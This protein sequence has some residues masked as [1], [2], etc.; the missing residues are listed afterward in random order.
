MLKKSYHE[1]KNIPIEAYNTNVESADI[2]EYTE[3]MMLKYGINVN[4]ARAVTSIND[5]LIIGVRRILWTM[6][7][8]GLTPGKMTKA[9]EFLGRVQKYHP[10]GDLP[11]TGTFEQMSKYWETNGLLLDIQ[12]NQGSVSGANAA[13]ARYLEGCLSKYAYE[14][15][16]KEFDPEITDMMDNYTRTAKEP[17]SLPSKYPNFLMS[18]SEGIGWGISQTMPPFNFKEVC[19]T[20]IALI[21]DPTLENVYL[22]PDSPRGYEIMETPNIIDI[23]NEGTGSLAIRACIKYNKDGHYLSITGFPEATT[24]KDIISEISRLTS[25]KKLNGIKDVSDQTHFNHVEF[26]IHLKKEA[27]PNYI[28]REL[29][30]K[31]SCKGYATLNMNFAERTKI[32]HLGIKDALLLWIDRRIDQKQ[33][34][35]NKKLKELNERIHTLTILIWI[36]QSNKIDETIDIIRNSPT[37]EDAVCKL[38]NA[39]NISSYQADVIA[40]MKLGQFNKKHVGDWV[41]EYDKIQ[42]IIPKISEIV[43]SKAKIKEVIIDE[44]EDGI[45]MFGK[46]RACKIISNS[47]N[48]D[49]KY[50]IIVTKRYIKKLSS[51]THQ[52]GYLDSKDEVIGIF[53][54]MIDDNVIMLV[55]KKGRCYSF[56]ISKLVPND[57][58]SR[59]TELISSFG[60]KSDIVKAVNMNKADDSMNLIMFT[61]KGNIKKTPL[62]QYISKTSKSDF[63]GIILSDDDELCNVDMCKN[64]NEHWV[65]VYT[66]NGVGI[67]INMASITTTNKATMGGNFLKL[68]NGDYVVGSCDMETSDILIITT[69]GKMKIC[70]VCEVMKTT[71]RRQEMIRLTSLDNGDSVFRIIPVHDNMTHFTVIMQSGEKCLINI[72]DINRTTRISKGFK[73]INVKRNDS[74]IK[75]K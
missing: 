11:T 23:C 36:A 72:N 32:V 75:I 33:K 58:S 31:T 41:A 38:V 53:T 22:Y 35:Y 14:C 29:Y 46:P 62:S 43:R 54:S 19:E 21:K 69:K 71:K 61:K 51:Y 6:Y 57:L 60:V 42:S 4:L 10:H 55:D 8:L 45:R 9:S 1:M 30:S 52:I 27:D 39:Y 40:S 16:F 49:I 48:Y 2:S 59:G 7:E 63:T 37:M 68:D 26:W 74:I 66:N 5:G 44:L 15:F 34:I 17:I 24:M 67:G 50:N 56:P 25:E 20:T 12:G 13:A 28:I 70:G 73:M 64:D 18:K 3:Y 65:L 47:N